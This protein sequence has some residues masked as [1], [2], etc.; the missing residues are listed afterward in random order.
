[1]R[2]IS[3]IASHF[4]VVVTVLT[5]AISTTGFTFY[6]HECSHNDTHSIE[7]SADQCCSELVKE[8][9]KESH[10][11]CHIVDA[12]KTGTA[13][14]S[15]VQESN[16]CETDLNY[17]RLSEWYLESDYE[18]S[19]IDCF[20]NEIEIQACEQDDVNDNHLTIPQVPPVLKKSKQPLYRLFHRVKID[21]PLI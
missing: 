11:C 2:I 14:N 17:Y 21:P 1:M 12:K 20:A 6:T 7:I 5:F 16:C 18:Q 15:D 4:L 3:K 9:P 13:C 10:G 19:T 8:I